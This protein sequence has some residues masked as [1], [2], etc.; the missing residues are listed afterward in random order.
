[1]P[2]LEDVAKRAHLSKTTVSRVLNKRGYLSQKT[3]DKVYQAIEELDYHPN[4][5]ARQLYKNKTD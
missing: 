4:V 5:V 3:I 1:M 2:K